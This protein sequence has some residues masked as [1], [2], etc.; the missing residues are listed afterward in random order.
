MPILTLCHLHHHLQISQGPHVPS[1]TNNRALSPWLTHLLSDVRVKS[2]SLGW[3]FTAFWQI[4]GHGWWMS[5]TGKQVSKRVRMMSGKGT[6]LLAD[7]WWPDWKGDDCEFRC[8]M[9]VLVLVAKSRTRELTLQFPSSS[10]SLLPPT[11]VTLEV[12]TTT[13]P[14]WPKVVMEAVPYPALPS[15]SVHVSSNKCSFYSGMVLL[16]FE[17]TRNCFSCLSNLIEMEEVSVV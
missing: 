1:S 10:A 15:Y 17:A 5:T 9:G 2:L 6:L 14:V 13:H 11:M 12:I 4:A 3:H 7:L 8:T 16:V